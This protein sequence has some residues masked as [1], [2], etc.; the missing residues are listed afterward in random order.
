MQR[1]AAITQK[2]T[3]R[4]QHSAKPERDIAE[5]RRRRRRSGS[6]RMEADVSS[7]LSSSSSRAPTVALMTSDALLRDRT[8]PRPWS[9]D[10]VRS[11]TA[12]S[13]LMASLR[14]WPSMLTQIG[15]R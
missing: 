14:L 4:D 13:P 15:A 11:I 1:A 5:I 2:H 7:T 10:E 8:Y 12:A 6:P 3:R 9:S